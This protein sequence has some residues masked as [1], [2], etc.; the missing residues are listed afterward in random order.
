MEEVEGFLDGERDY[1]NLKGQT[2]P[3]VYP[4]AFVYIYSFLRYITEGGK[5]IMMGKRSP[6]LFD[7]KHRLTSFCYPWFQL[8]LS[9]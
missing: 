1:M 7:V 2:G 3:L 6:S 9:S 8:N 5:D 4:A